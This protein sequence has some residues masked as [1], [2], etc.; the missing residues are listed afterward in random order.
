MA[1]KKAVGRPPKFTSVKRME[2]LIDAYFKSCEGHPL[3]DENTGRAVTDKHDR[4]VIVNSRPPTVT[5]LALALGFKTRASLMDYQ[6]KPQFEDA[7]L[8]AKSRI[9]QYTE[10]RLF[11][12]DGSAGARF[13]LQ[14]NFRGWKNEADVTLRTR[15]EGDEIMDEIRAR[16]TAC[17]SQNFNSDEANTSSVSA[18]APPPSP[19]GK[20]F[21]K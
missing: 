1:E 12:R 18:D 2:A 21:G 7:I 10:E 5:G 17:E 16:L 13:S 14:N 15:D 4:P 9:E 11:D 8:R 20:A 3:I 6:G 19:E